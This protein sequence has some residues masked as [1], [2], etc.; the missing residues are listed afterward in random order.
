MFLLS[1]VILFPQCISGF[2]LRIRVS[3]CIP[4]LLLFLEPSHPWPWKWELHE[5][6]V[7][8]QED[9]FDYLPIKAA[10]WPAL[11]GLTAFVTLTRENVSSFQFKDFKVNIGQH[12]KGHFW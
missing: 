7:P 11:C 10:L 3:S 5:G 6:I 2:S 9:Y 4:D 8:L 1:Q 12:M